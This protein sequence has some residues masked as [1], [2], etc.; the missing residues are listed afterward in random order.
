MRSLR[1]V[2]LVAVVAAVALTAAACNSSSGGGGSSSSSSPIVVG[3]VNSLSGA[4][5]FPEASQAAKAVF[6]R[7]NAKGGVNGHKIQYTAL[8]DKGDPSTAAQ[9]ARKLVSDQNAVVLDGSAS[10]VDCEV[11]AAFYKQ[12]GISSVP[13]VG[14][15]P[16]CFASAP[17][18]PVNTGPYV[19]TQID[20]QYASEQ[21]HLNKICAFF[22]IIG[23][24][25]G[26][27][28]K[29][30]KDWE[31]S[32][33]K[34]LALNDESVS[35]SVT[36]FS[37]FVLHAQ[38]LGCDGIFFNGV[39][40]TVVGFAKAMAA[41]G[42]TTP[43]LVLS[44]AYTVQAAQAVG[45]PAFPMYS[46]SEFAPYTDANSAEN[47]D[48]RSLMQSDNIPLTS[49]SQGGYLS[50]T[51]LLDVLKGIKGDITRDSVTK[52]LHSMKPIQNAMVGSPWVFGTAATHN[53]NQSVK[54]VRLQQG[55][56]TVADP[57]WVTAKKS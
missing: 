46:A 12:S 36:D 56:W 45:N 11:N 54:I 29:A 52:A 9:S 23:G 44:S 14:V 21:L 7:A 26:A 34:K 17:I 51:Y 49:F 37:P 47:A 40:P 25:S 57:Q 33:G 15:D 18:A 50:A 4:A 28:Q 30:V 42:M 24:T 39:E 10:L 32:T 5:T 1:K 6:D 27:Y 3:S 53:P 48:W 19:G 16:G 13:G 38:Q 41:Q 43:L 31:S 8:D 22:T 35:A 55:N 20:L 2:G